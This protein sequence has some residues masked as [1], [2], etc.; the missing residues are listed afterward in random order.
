[1]YGINAYGQLIFDV[2]LK[3]NGE[4]S[5]TITGAR[6]FQ[7]G[8]KTEYGYAHYADKERGYPTVTIEPG[9]TGKCLWTAASPLIG[10]TSYE[11]VIIASSSSGGVAKAQTGTAKVAS[12]QT[13]SKGGATIQATSTP[14]AAA[15]QVAE[16]YFAAA[17]RG[18]S[19][20][21]KTLMNPSTLETT[22]ERE[23][24]I[25]GYDVATDI[26]LY[27]QS[28][29]GT[30]ATRIEDMK[31]SSDGQWAY[32]ELVFLNNGQVIL[33]KDIALQNVSGLWRMANII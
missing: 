10:D 21:V 31:I 25:P 8:E 26:K 6:V 32:C 3:N 7:N 19:K 12:T 17:W 16:E 29:G 2:T 24:R 23:G 20:T 22:Q 1:L 5:T 11:L 18:D 30:T 15:T 27:L 28:K 33:K 4:T 13:Q 14:A 9:K